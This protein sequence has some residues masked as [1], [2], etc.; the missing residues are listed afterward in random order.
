M[1]PAVHVEA[2]KLGRSLVGRLG[3]AVLVGGL[4]AICVGLLLAIR[5]GDPV[6]TAKLG[7]TATFDWPG[8][9]GS[10]M[11]VMGAGG[12][13]GFGVVLAWIFAR[14]F[15]DGT[16][17]GLFGLPVSRGAIALAKLAV[18][19]AWAVAV[20]L[21]CVA[22]TL[23]VGVA[24]GLG[25]PDA[26]SW[27]DLAR[28]AVLGILTA[29]VAAPVAWVSTV[30]RSLLAGVTATIGLVVVAQVGVLAGAGGWLPL[31]APALWAMTAGAEV[32]AAQLALA[33]GVAGLTAAAT[34]LSWTRLQLDR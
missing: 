6:L 5:S 24:F 17:T 31:A 10:A 12:M 25:V 1:T 2:V 32:S 22:A 3:S 21:A 14:E 20:S 9:I 30:G 7:D 8:L 4:A 23:L 28:L 11:Q 13:V 34:V 16:I 18:Y 29:A 15:A 19:L 26:E 33:V 27:A